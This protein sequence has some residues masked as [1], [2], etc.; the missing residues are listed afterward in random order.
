MG[1]KPAYQKLKKET[2]KWCSK[3]I[4]LRDMPN[5]WGYCCSCGKGTV[6]GDAGHFI[7]RGLGGSSG[8]YFDERNIHLQCKPCNAFKQGAPVEYRKFMLKR[9]GQNVID[10]LELKHRIHNYTL[11]ELEGL[12]LFYKQAYEELTNDKT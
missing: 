9:Y 3:Y 1:K 8:I 5:G 11:M 2:W 7:G 6:K 10:E 4:R 12:K